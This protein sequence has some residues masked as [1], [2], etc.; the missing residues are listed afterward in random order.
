MSFSSLPLLNIQDLEGLCILDQLIFVFASDLIYMTIDRV[1][2]SS[3]LVIHC[4]NTF[5]GDK[6][7][8][9]CPFNIRNRNHPRYKINFFLKI[10]FLFIR[11]IG[12]LIVPATDIVYSSFRSQ[13]RLGCVTQNNHTRVK[14]I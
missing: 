11:L 9:D 7:L 10:T 8:S 4:G 2:H 14:Y 6:T 1:G 3:Y 12:R 5:A 13:A